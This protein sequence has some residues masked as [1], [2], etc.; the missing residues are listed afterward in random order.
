[1]SCKHIGRRASIFYVFFLQPH[2]SSAEQGVA[3]GENEA[4]WE[5]PVADSYSRVM[6]SV[7]WFDVGGVTA[8][9]LP[10]RVRV[11]WLVRAAQQ[12]CERLLSRSSPLLLF[13][14][15]SSALLLLHRY[16]AAP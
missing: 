4:Y 15:S 6:R 16:V 5:K 14:T 7:C 8:D 12:G 3:W 1:M 9:L 11:V 13:R 2:N 10:G